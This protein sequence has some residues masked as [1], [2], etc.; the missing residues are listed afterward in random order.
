MFGLSQEDLSYILEIFKKYPAIQEVSLF[1]SRA[2]GTH[3]KGSDVDLALKGEGLDSIVLEI[4]GKLNDES[5]MP[6]EFDL[7]DYNTID[8]TDLKDHIDR[9]GKVIYP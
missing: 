1:G 4:S 2:L 7:I 5:P 3:K 8:N 9:V 6:Y